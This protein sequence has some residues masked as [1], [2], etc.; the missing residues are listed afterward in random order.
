MFIFYLGTVRLRTIFYYFDFLI[1]INPL[2]YVELFLSLYFI[3]AIGIGV[4]LGDSGLMPFHLMLA[5][6]FGVIAFFSVV[7][8][9]R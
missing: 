4:Y 9:K 5:F 8:A 7:H 1:K 6:G 3:A 2:T